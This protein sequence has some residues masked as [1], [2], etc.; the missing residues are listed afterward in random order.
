MHPK[1]A[2]NRLPQCSG[3]LTP[4]S[5][6]W[7]EPGSQSRRSVTTAI[8]CPGIHRCTWP[9]GRARCTP[10]KTE[11]GGQRAATHDT[12]C[13]RTALR[14]PLTQPPQAHHPPPH[15]HHLL[16]LVGIRRV[17]PRPPRLAWPCH[18]CHAMQR[19]A[20][21]APGRTPRNNHIIC[22][23]G[24]GESTTTRLPVLLSWHPP[25]ATLSNA[26]TC[27]VG[28]LG[29]LTVQQRWWTNA[30]LSPCTQNTQPRQHRLSQ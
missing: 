17:A 29:M 23:C 25:S 24:L 7:Q 22:A 8:A 20:I 4:D 11:R 6:P 2:V 1:C 26:S 14:R 10:H 27:Y 9:C 12:T 21:E 15:P 5:W 16:W 13:G 19:H 3:P 28:H 30:S 18:A